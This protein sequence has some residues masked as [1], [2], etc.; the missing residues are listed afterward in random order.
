MLVKMFVVITWLC[1]PA[2]AK[3]DLNTPLSANKIRL[4][5]VLVLVAVGDEKMHLNTQSDAWAGPD[6]FT[7]LIPVPLFV[8]TS[9]HM[10]ASSPHQ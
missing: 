4:V 9:Q 2:A 8:D 6:Y 3:M 10:G 1:L 7:V 5:V